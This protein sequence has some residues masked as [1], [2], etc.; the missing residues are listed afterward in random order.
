MLIIDEK[1]YS[2][3]PYISNIEKLKLLE[4]ILARKQRIKRIS[5]ELIELNNEA[6]ELESHKNSTNHSRSVN[7]I[8]NDS[9][10]VRTPS[11]TA[12]ATTQTIDE[13]LQQ[14]KKDLGI[15]K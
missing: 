15:I 7:T 8:E 10:K 2:S 13:Q 6:C 4:S 12:V 11:Q 5:A 14:M 9:A 3:A 1:N